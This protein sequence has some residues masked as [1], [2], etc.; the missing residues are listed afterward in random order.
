MAGRYPDH[1]S[2]I[3]V[4]DNGHVFM[5]FAVAG[6]VNADLF[7]PVKTFFGADVQIG[8]DTADNGSDRVP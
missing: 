7:K 3:V 6:F 5:S 8:T 4:D 1:P 2:G